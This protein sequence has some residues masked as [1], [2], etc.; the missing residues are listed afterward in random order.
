MKNQKGFTL[1]ELVAV[2]VVLGVLLIIAIPTISNYIKEA[3]DVS[4]DSHEKALVEAARSYTIDCINKNEKDC[5][6]PHDNETINVYVDRLIEEEYIGKLQD[7]KNQSAY[8]SPDKSFVKVT[9]D[10]TSN[11]VYESCLF[12]SGYKT[13][14][15]ICVRY[16]GD[17]DF[18]VCGEI[19]GSSSAWTNESRTISIGCI[20][21]T[22]GCTQDRFSKTFTEST[23]T[24]YITIVD[25]SGKTTQCP[26]PVRVDNTPPTCKIIENPTSKKLPKLTEVADSHSGVATYGIGTSANNP[27]YNKKEILSVGNGVTRIYGYVKDLAGNEGICSKTIVLSGL[28]NIQ[29]DPNG[30]SG[31]MGN[32][33]CY[34][35][36][37]CTIRSNLFSKPNAKF[38]YW[39]V[40]KDGTG[41][42]IHDHETVSLTVIGDKLPL[43]AHWEEYEYY[44]PGPIVFDGTNYVNTGVYLFSAE[45][46]KKDFEARVTINEIKSDSS[47]ASVMLGNMDEKGVPYYGFLVRTP[48]TFNNNILIVSNSPSLSSGDLAYSY[49]PNMV[50]VVKRVNNQFYYSLD[51]GA[52]FRTGSNFS[53]FTDTFDVP[54]T[55]GARIWPEGQENSF[56]LDRFFKGTLSN[57]SIRYLNNERVLTFN[58]NGGSECNPSTIT[59]HDNTA[60]GTLCTPTRENYTFLGWNTKAD[61]TGTNVTNATVATSSYTVFAN[62]RPNNFTVT[63]DRQSGT[64][65]STSVTATYGLAMPAATA[66]T[67]TGYTFGGYYTGTN[68]SGTQ[69]YNGSMASVKNWDITSAT[70]LYAKWTINQMT[71]TYNSN[72][73]NACNPTTKKVNWNTAWGTLCTPS[74]SGYTFLGW[75]T[76]ADGTGSTITN[77]T[78]TTSSY[79]I[80]AIWCS[81]PVGRSWS[82]STGAVRS[83]TIECPGIYRLEV[84]GGQGGTDASAQ[85]GRGGYARGYRSFNRNQVLYIVVGGQGANSATCGAG[86]YNGGGKSG[87]SGS[88][89]GGGGATHIASTNRGFLTNYNSYRGELYIVAGGGGGAGNNGIVTGG[90]GGGS[91]GSTAKGGGGTQTGGGAGG[92]AGSFGKGGDRNGDG[93]GG[94][95]GFFGGGAGEAD[96][97]GG[98]GSGYIG[99]VSNGSMSNGVKTGAGSATITYC[100]SSNC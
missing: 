78:V 50:V 38:K 46:Y 94:G 100:G 45:N 52:S 33:D 99:G 15:P 75:N 62:W 16:E 51:G 19:S 82:F 79:T 89:G 25:R 9:K 27:D 70:I 8:C 88:S 37:N 24:G 61:G 76:K 98:G 35:G 5:T 57:I 32:T 20:D 77:A 58:S 48:G 60:W 87:C 69:Y 11:Y 86:G 44:H 47:A 71:L 68:G 84:W 80:Y 54:A 90:G 12:C 34:S 43:Y 93:G 4:Y 56:G 10:E 81:Y 7:P 18:P 65:G 64:G 55:L 66:P 67:R 40:N 41:R 29:Y 96:G 72:G 14:N 39:T 3:R 31:S 22:S 73:G 74:R 23:E 91:S 28:Y 53:T 63:L 42:I 2:I 17:S 92:Y 95:G 1:I 26:V 36:E 59:A 97:A 21:H 85:G 6:V 49:T 83:H 13:D 30:G